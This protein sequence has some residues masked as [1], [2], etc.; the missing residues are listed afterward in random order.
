MAEIIVPGAGLGGTLMPVGV[1]KTGFTI[2]SMVTAAAH[3][4]GA[5]LRG[6]AAAIRPSRNAVCLADFDDGGIAF[7][8]QPQVP[9]RNV[10]RAA[11]GKWVH[12]AK[13]GFEKYFCAK[14]RR[15]GA[16]RFMNAIC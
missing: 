13:V 5:L 12:L 11:Q 8:A 2:G 7:A 9:P 3:N 16:S 6:G 10:K 15:A 14:S 1:P 4:L